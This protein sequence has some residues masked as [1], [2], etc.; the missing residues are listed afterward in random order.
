MKFIVDTQL[1]FKLSMFFKRK[2]YDSIHTTDTIKGHLL[3]DPDI[4]S[5]SIVSHRTVVTKD[6]DFKNNYYAKGAPPKVLYLTFGNISNKDLLAYFE[7]YFD[8]IIKLFQEGEEFI[9]FNR[10]GIFIL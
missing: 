6:S 2:G 8:N 9:E 10:S 1:P 3:Q 7:D 5:I 4:I